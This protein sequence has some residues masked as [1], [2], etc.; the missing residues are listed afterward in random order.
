[1]LISLTAL[2][3]TPVLDL[4]FAGCPGT[5]EPGSASP[6]RCVSAFREKTSQVNPCGPPFVGLTVAHLERLALGAGDGSAGHGHCVASQGLPSLLGLENPA[7]P[8]RKT[9][10]SP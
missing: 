10:G 9:D 3:I 5:G 4:P 2:L 6:N 8:T 1:M 7:G